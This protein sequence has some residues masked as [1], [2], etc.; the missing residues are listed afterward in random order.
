MNEAVI[1]ALRASGM[2]LYEARIYLGLV[3]HGPQNGNELS[4]AARVP[5]SK[6]YG[7]LEKM[8]QDGIIHSI[9]SGTSNEFVCI[10]P[11][12]L[13]ERL[14][15]QFNEPIDFLEQTLPTLASFEPASEVFVMQGRAAILENCRY[16]LNGA[17]SNVS[18]SLWPDEYGE[19]AEAFSAAAGRGVRVEGMFYGTDLPETGSWLAHS[20]KEI[21]ATRVHGR[22]LTVV[23]DREEAVV[24]H[25][26]DRSEPSGVRTR[27]PALALITQEYLHHDYV[28]QRMQVFVGFEQWDRYWQAD[29]DLRHQILE[30]SLEASAEAGHA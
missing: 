30:E 18:A 19:L 24:A 3:Q 6:V 13:V 4:K 16:L 5:S 25:I 2:S 14:R 29:A 15:Q 21:V 27:S 23:A 9:R 12:D 20:Y 22:L 11:R 17:L 28:L 10:S 1:R 7:L 26:P 8:S